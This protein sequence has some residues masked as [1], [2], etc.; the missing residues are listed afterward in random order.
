MPVTRERLYE[1]VWAEP[2]TVVAA[3]YEVSSSFLARVC[4][5]LRVPRPPRGY[6]AQLRF[7]KRV[8]TPVLPGA[9]PG[10]EVEWL[11]GDLSLP[12]RSRVFPL[13]SLPQALETVPTPKSKRASHPLIVE[14]Q[15]FYA[16]G[17]VTETGF[18][19]PNKQLVPDIYVSQPALE[20]GLKL[21]TQL[22]VELER[23]GHRVVIAPRGDRLRRMDLEENL[24]GDYRRHE[25]R[26]APGRPTV[27]YFKTLAVGL[28]LYEQRETVE[29]TTGDGSTF[30]RPSWVRLSEV[31]TP[32]R[33]RWHGWTPSKREMPNGRL[34][35]RAYSPYWL[36][37]W[38]KTWCEE[39]ARDLRERIGEIC[40][41]IEGSA[42]GVV[43]LLED[44]ERQEAARQRELEIQHQKWAREEAER[45]RAQTLKE[46]REQ[47]LQVISHWALAQNVEKFFV[48]LAKSVTSLEEPDAKRVS[49]RIERAHQMF[50]GTEALQHFRAWKSPEER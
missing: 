46:S 11:R 50:G 42:P 47:L 29:V 27:A 33:P 32:K 19:R 16:V 48:D 44:G 2:M 26:W 9:R 49:A 6:W 14:A 22:Y 30:S 40:Q 4:E 25:E 35:I 3:R 38:E 8:G 36:A 20:R 12:T 37:P 21:A 41:D 5:T 13:P 39:R 45:R 28:T 31:P 23:R 15:G 7:G 34:A 18:L 17:R 1:E 24:S 43:R 10:D